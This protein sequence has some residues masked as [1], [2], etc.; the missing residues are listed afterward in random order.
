M[1]LNLGD[2]APDFNLKSTDGSNISLDS[3]K[4]NK[5]ILYFYPKDDTPGCTIEACEFRDSNEEL[6][7][8]NV[9]VLGV[10]PDDEESH[11]Q[12][13]NKF[14][15]NFPL[16][17]DPGA[18]LAKTYGAWGERERQGK[19]IVGILRTTFAIDENGYTSNI[20]PKV[21]PEGHAKEIIDWVKE[22]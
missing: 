18:E 8:L 22:N 2:K 9:T 20:W 11:Q 7:K 21:S 6:Q 19:I 14:G 10:S 3:L 1:V 13:T 4:G 15:L 12:F 16:L 17:V 5:T